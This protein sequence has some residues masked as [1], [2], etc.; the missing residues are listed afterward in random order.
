M[1][2]YRSLIWIV[3]NEGKELVCN[4]EKIRDDFHEGD[5][6][7]DME[8]DACADVSQIVGTERW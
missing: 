7:T 3:D 6:L 4:V 5:T 2:G 1:S 8:R